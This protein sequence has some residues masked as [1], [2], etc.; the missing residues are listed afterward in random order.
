MFFKSRFDFNKISTFV[1]V[2]VI[3]N[4]W[5]RDYIDEQ[6]KLVFA[7]TMLPKNIWIVQYEKYL[8]IKKLLQKYPRIKHLHS[9]ENLKYFGRF[10]LV[11][12]LDTRYVWILDDDTMPSHTWVETCV[13][14]CE[15]QNAIVCSNGR[16]IGKNDYTP[17]SSTRHSHT[18]FVGDARYPQLTNYCLTDTFVDYGCSSYFFKTEWIKHFWSVWPATLQTGEDMHLSAT[19]KIRAEIPTV[20]PQQLT[21]RE[22]GNIKPA[23]SS[24]EHA[25]W[26]KEGFIEQRQ[27]V[28]RYLIDER[29]WKPLLWSIENTT[30][31]HSIDELGL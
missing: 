3:L 8:S 1:D 5:K 28:L 9:T 19:C 16:I 29:G 21:A 18:Q 2:S 20:V 12:H 31:T 26:M 17:E 22:S 4:I 24:D 7:Q 6:L 11:T 25:S 30:D 10:S 23:Y 14:V 13:D 15:T 27:K